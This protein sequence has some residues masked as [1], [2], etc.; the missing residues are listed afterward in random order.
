MSTRKKATTATE[1]E[2]QVAQQKAEMEPIATP[3]QTTALEVQ[4]PAGALAAIDPEFD[5]NDDELGKGH[6]GRRKEDNKVPLLYLLQATS[7]PVKACRDGSVRA[8]MLYDTVSGKV[9]DITERAVTMHICLYT[10]EGVI[11]KPLDKGGGFQGTID[12]DSEEVQMAIAKAKADNGGKLQSKIPWKDG[13]ELVETV[14]AFGVIDDGGDLHPFA[15]PHTSTKLGAIRAITQQ[16]EGFR[17]DRQKHKKAPPMWNFAV[18]VTSFEKPF[19]KTNTTAYVVKYGPAIKEGP[20]PVAVDEDGRRVIKIL[21]GQKDLRASFMGKSHP[22][23]MLCQA[24]FDG[25]TSGKLKVD[26]AQSEKVGGQAEDDGP[27]PF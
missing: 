8:G 3:A 7:K 10:T 27:V 6:E 17:L 13:N 12:I 16:M 5:F 9:W 15:F 22:A 4:Q 11:W 18:G 1:A 24:L 14:T 23:V 26:H 21:P 19:A 20:G 25:L 2:A